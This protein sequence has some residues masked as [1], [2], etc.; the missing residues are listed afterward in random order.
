MS[1]VSIVGQERVKKIL[2]NAILHKQFAQAYLFYGSDGTGKDAMAI[3][4]TKAL[5]CSISENGNAC[6]EC[7][8][9]KRIAK[10]QHQNLK[11]VFAMPTVKSEND[12]DSS[13][14]DV[15]SKASKDII[16]EIQAQIAAKAQNPYVHIAIPKATAIRIATIRDVKKELSLSLFSGGKRVVIIFDA[17]LMNVQAQN[18]FLKTLEEPPANTVLILTTSN[19]NN[20]LPTIISRC[21]QV[22]FEILQSSEIANSLTTKNNISQTDAKLIAQLSFGNYGRALELLG[23]NLPAERLHILDFLRSLVTKT[24]GEVVDDAEKLTKEFDRASFKQ[25]ILLLLFWFRDVF[26][27]QHSGAI[28]NIDQQDSLQKFAAR[29]PNF[30]VAHAI[31]LLE[32]AL[33][34]NDKNV[35]IR[36]LIATL[37]IDLRTLILQ[38]K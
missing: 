14:D 37:A 27:L 38:G 2:Q 31:A 8:N 4:F 28:F 16:E 26:A 21:Q 19:L 13:D 7:A 36:L 33:S 34:L 25:F 35:Y 9:C 18:A 32:N 30:Q 24:E 23:E 22:P 20:L 11:L 17:H 5:N 6:D 3:E 12:D 1:W 29:Y 15:T 10:L